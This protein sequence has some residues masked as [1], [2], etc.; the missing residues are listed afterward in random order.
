MTAKQIHLET[1]VMKFLSAAL[2]ITALGATTAQAKAPLSQV[3]YIND[4]LFAAAVGDVIRKECDSISAR[5]VRVLAGLNDIKKHAKD[6]GYTDAE[7]EAYADDKAEKAKL[8]ARRDVYLREHGA[9]AGKSETYCQVGRDEIAKGSLI[10]SL[11]KA[12]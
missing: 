5:F 7:I 3:D 1:L 6:L 11:L 9:V 4:R 10:G 2:L 8:K 12:R